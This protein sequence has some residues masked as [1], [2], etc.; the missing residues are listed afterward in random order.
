MAHLSIN[1]RMVF[2]RRAV[3]VLRLAE[4]CGATWRQYVRVADEEIGGGGQT[5]K[6]R[7]RILAHTA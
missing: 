3:P 5:M 1:R 7:K 4:V 2:D 6:Y